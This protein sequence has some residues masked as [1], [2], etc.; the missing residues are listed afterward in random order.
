MYFRAQTKCI[1]Y[2]LHWY[3]VYTC[4]ANNNITNYN[5]IMPKVFDSALPN[6][7]LAFIDSVTNKITLTFNINLYSEFNQVSYSY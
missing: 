7:Q 3:V 2:I 1:H 6:F 5:G 4:Q